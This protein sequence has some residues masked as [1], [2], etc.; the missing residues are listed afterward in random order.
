MRRTA[1]ALSGCFSPSGKRYAS[2]EPNGAVAIVGTKE[3]A[4]LGLYAPGDGAAADQCPRE[5]PPAACGCAR[6]RSLPKLC[7]D[8]V[9]VQ[10]E[11]P[12]HQPTNF[13]GRPSTGGG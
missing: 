7:W 12:H 4:A 6:P 11:G 1:Q 8:A 9:G 5:A 3:W 10:A 2:G 13:A